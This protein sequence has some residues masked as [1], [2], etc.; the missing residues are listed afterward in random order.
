MEFI[1]KIMLIIHIFS[2]ILGMGPG[3]VL[4]QVVSAAQSMTELRHAY[5]VRHRLHIFVMIGGILLL[6][7]GLVMGA[8]HPYLFKTGWY[9]ASILLYLIALALGPILLKPLA[10]PIKALLENYESEEI[11][12]QYA[13][14]AKKLFRYERVT[15]FIFIIIILLMIIKPTF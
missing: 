6:T 7:T 15:S 12:H 5:E 8:I 9:I 3:F 2:A 11:P 10:E 14:Y 4:I 13:Q 1:Y